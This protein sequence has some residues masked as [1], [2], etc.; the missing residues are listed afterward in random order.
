MKFSPSLKNYV[1]LV[2]YI[3]KMK[4]G[5]FIIH[6]MSVDV[7]GRS[8]TQSDGLYLRGP[9][10]VGFNLTTDGEFDI[11][12]KRLCNLA[13]AINENDA[14]NYKSVNRLIDDK[15]QTFIN[16]YDD[17]TSKN[18]TAVKQEIIDH[19]RAEFEKRIV[20]LQDSIKKDLKNLQYVL[21][22]H[23]SGIYFG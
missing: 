22:A 3:N 7:F 15:I 19:C 8:L 13:S 2:S 17:I 4:R 9:P 21:Q 10:G 18:I 14:M 6:A 1:K 16:K 11:K 12:D 20:E 23:P 5:K